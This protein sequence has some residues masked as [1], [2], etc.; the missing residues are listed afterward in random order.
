MVGAGV[1]GEDTEI[2]LLLLAPD[3]RVLRLP[4]LELRVAHLLLEILREHLGGA[5]ALG[6]LLLHPPDHG[7]GKH[8]LEGLPEHPLL[9]RLVPLAPHQVSSE[10]FRAR[11]FAESFRD[12]AF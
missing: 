7:A 5:R 10:R 4:L 11:K 12:T 2:V 6:E 8:V 3:Y 9:H 1:L